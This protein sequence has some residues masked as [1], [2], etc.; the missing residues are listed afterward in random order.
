VLSAL[1]DADFIA[2]EGL[3]GEVELNDVGGV[4]TNILF[5]VGTD[6]V[7]GARQTLLPAAQ[8]AVEIAMPLASAEVYRGVEG[9][10][11]RGSQVG[12][13]RGDETLAGEVPTVDDLDLPSG[14]AVA[15][16]TLADLLRGVV[17]HYGVGEGSTAAV[18]EWWQP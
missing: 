6:G 2:F 17:G 13:I 5:V 8:A 7:I 3:G 1:I 11:V 9:G 12:V 15:L 10:G 4:G 16:L 18:P 14:S